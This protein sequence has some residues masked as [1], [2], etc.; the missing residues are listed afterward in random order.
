MIAKKES[1]DIAFFRWSQAN[2]MSAATQLYQFQVQIQNMLHDMS[3][4]HYL[5]ELDLET[6]E[7]IHSVLDDQVIHQ[8][9][10]LKFFHSWDS[11]GDWASTIGLM[12]DLLELY[13]HCMSGDPMKPFYDATS[14]DA[15]DGVTGKIPAGRSYIKFPS[16]FQHTQEGKPGLGTNAP[17]DRGQAS[18]RTIEMHS[19]ETVLYPGEWKN[20]SGYGDSPGHDETQFD[21]ND[22]SG[23]V[24]GGAHASD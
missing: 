3:A 15:A 18:S 23:D 10:R 2:I 4:E 24:V 5:D 19:V 16:W 1:E 7:N 8:K 12:P 14:A 13:R 17:G 22:I 11:V 20:V 21:R 6:Q 9:S